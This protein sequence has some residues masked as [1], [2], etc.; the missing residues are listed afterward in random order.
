[1]E[2]FG[3]KD[4]NK[5]VKFE[6]MNQDDETENVNEQRI[7]RFIDIMVDD[8]EQFV[9][10]SASEPI[11][12]VSFVQ[13]TLT[14]GEIHLEIGVPEGENKNKLYYKICTKEECKS[15]FLEYF[16]NTFVPDMEEY[17]PFF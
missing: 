17:Q 11:E 12:N 5:Q 2:I 9:T 4:K 1:M 6:L 8:S 16:H 14:D 7:K 13:A 15:I 3:T 10:L